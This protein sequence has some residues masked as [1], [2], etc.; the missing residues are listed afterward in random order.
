LQDIEL[1]RISQ[2][3]SNDF[4]TVNLAAR[5][6]CRRTNHTRTDR[7]EQRFALELKPLN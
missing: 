6:H 7:F 1:A 2:E 5:E 4:V 3:V